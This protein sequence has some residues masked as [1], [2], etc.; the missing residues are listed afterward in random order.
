VDRREFLRVGIVGASG[1]VALPCLATVAGAQ[2]SVGPYGSIDDVEPDDNGVILPPGFTSRIV[3]IAGE[4]VGDTGYEW[5]AFP[6]G[7][8]TFEDGRSGWYHVCNS[9]V[10]VAGAGGVSAIHFAPD[11]EILEAYRILEGSI[12]N[13]AGGPTPWGTW[14]SCEEEAGGHGLVW[15]CDPAGKDPSVAHPAMGLFK[16][17]AVAVDPVAEQLYLTQDEPLGN[18]YRYTPQAYPDLSAG[19]LEAATVDPATA[20]VMW[21]EVPDPSGQSA[22]TETQVDGATVFPGG[23]GIWYHADFVYFTTKGDDRVHTINL[24]TQMY[25][26]VYEPGDALTADGRPVLSGVDNITVDAGTGD[27]Y[28]AEDGG[29]MEVVLITPDGVVT[30]F[31]RV[32][33]HPN[34]EITGPVFNPKRDRLYFSSQRGPTPKALP[35]IV[36]ELTRNDHTGG[37]TFEI[38]GP[39]RGIAVTPTPT[40]RPTP[41]VAP[42]ASVPSPT[43][44]PGTQADPTATAIPSPIATLAA[45]D[46]DDGGG[47]NGSAIAVGGVVAAATITTGAVIAVRNRRAA[48]SP[49][50]RRGDDPHHAKDG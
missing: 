31:M 32:I 36:P 18:L 46:V 8:G 9:E 11:G 34:S 12:S 14:L 24:R 38:T 7:A 20:S 37:M 2:S 49:Q 50:D 28:V 35:D 4:S 27:L 3:A 15:E 21:T 1:A 6:D 23:E 29:N 45:A 40:L 48:S 30:P 19:L 47:G 43:P 42:T 22:R 16:H 17:E 33:D 44:S 25:Q 10:H 41:T 13:C 5:H 26:R 39:F